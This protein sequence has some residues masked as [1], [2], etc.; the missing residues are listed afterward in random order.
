MNS[1]GSEVPQCPVI[2]EDQ[3]MLANISGYNLAH[4][5]RLVAAVVCGENYSV[6]FL[7]VFIR[8]HDH[9]VILFL[10]SV[11]SLYQREIFYC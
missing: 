3:H 2:H 1:S 11:A 8:Q 5:Y 6:I 10:A 9:A 7:F 4:V